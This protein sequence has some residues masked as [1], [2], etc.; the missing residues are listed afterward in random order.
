ML[1]HLTCFYII[2]IIITLLNLYILGIAM[3]N[4][5]VKLII[6]EVVSLKSNVTV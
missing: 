3:Y 1:S 2:I 4:K 6:P 5:S